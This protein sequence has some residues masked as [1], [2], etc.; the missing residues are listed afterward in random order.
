MTELNITAEITAL[1]QKINAYVATV[2]V[3]QTDAEARRLAVVRRLLRTACGIS[4]IDDKSSSASYQ[5]T[6]SANELETSI[7]M[8]NEL[9]EELAE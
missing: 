8:L 9:A 2:P 1:R 4:N 3:D 5:L 7:R 6:T